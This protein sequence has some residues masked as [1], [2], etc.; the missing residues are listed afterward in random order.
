MD[1]RYIA[2]TT[3]ST[4]TIATEQ[5]FLEHSKKVLATLQRFYLVIGTRESTI[6][7]RQ[8][9][10]DALCSVLVRSVES[11]LVFHLLGKLNL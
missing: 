1:Y 3:L 4:K 9:V 7:A 10:L 5:A 8:S 11:V 6:R 2:P